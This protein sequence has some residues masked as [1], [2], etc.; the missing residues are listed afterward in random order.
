MAAHDEDYV[1]AL[2]IIQLDYAGAYPLLAAMNGEEFIGEGGVPC[3]D[4]KQLAAIFGNKENDVKRRYIRNIPDEMVSEFSPNQ[5]AVYDVRE[6]AMHTIYSAFFELGRFTHYITTQRGR[7]GYFAPLL[8]AIVGGV[9]GN[10]DVL[11]RLTVFDSSLSSEHHRTIKYIRLI[12]SG[13]EDRGLVKE[14]IGTVVG[15]P[16]IQ[17]IHGSNKENIRIG[18][19]WCLWLVKNTMCANLSEAFK[20]TARLLIK[21]YYPTS[22]PDF[23]FTVDVSNGS[24]TLIHKVKGEQQ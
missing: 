24:V 2:D 12:E 9:R 1:I 7:Q 13:G 11:L 15:S 19:S 5:Y 18:R 17:E 21:K 4:E 10:R 6:T 22:W 3:S 20:L 16:P 14:S 8:D 23:D